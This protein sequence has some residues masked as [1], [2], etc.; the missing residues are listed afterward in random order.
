VKIVNVKV[1]FIE[2]VIMLTGNCYEGEEYV[3]TSEDAAYFKKSIEII[4]ETDE[5]AIS[6]FQ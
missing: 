6:F 3:L 2:D 5:K 4:E 1:R